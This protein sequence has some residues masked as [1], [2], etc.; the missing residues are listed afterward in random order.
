[1]SFFGF[2]EF[3]ETLVKQEDFTGMHGTLDDFYFITRNMF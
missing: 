3:L 2:E 1:M